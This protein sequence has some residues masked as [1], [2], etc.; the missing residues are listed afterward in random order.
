MP[1][2]K[3]VF[4]SDCEG[5]ISKNDNAFELASHYIPDGGKFFSV[6]SKYDDVLADVVKK[7]KYNAG[8]T[9]KLILPFMKAHN[10]TNHDMEKFSSD[11]ILLVPG[12]IGT[13]ETVRDSMPSYIVS[14]SYQQ[15]INALC[16]AVKFPVRNTYSTKVNIDGYQMR[17]DEAAR[18]KE[19]AAEISGM[20]V[21][22]IPT[23]CN[24]LGDFSPD[25]RKYVARLDDIIWDEVSKMEIGHI[26]KD[27]KP[28]GGHE[29]ANAVKDIVRKENTDLS[30]V[31]YVGDSITDEEAF[32]LV[33]GSNGLAVSFN[34]N[35]YAVNSADV[36]IMSGTTRPTTILA[37]QFKHGGKQGAIEY[38]ND[39]PKLQV[40]T[41]ENVKEFSRASSKF[42]KT[43]RGE[44]VGKLG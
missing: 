21:V 16:K 30:E 41:E 23:P 22:N 11:N 40:L 19:L 4:V 15:Y 10:V 39:E 6:L 14:T 27:V 17:S 29:K 44:S 24:S 5:P 9:L 35:S 32:K 18:L 43:I 1:E 8:D 2:P 37:I 3:R 25:D 12:A 42:R 13:L 38:V 20:P 31:M 33:R 34:G 26:L 36:G 7:P 28:V